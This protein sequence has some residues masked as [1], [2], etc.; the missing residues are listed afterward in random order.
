[1]PNEIITLEGPLVRIR[2]SALHE[3][4]EWMAF[5]EWLEARPALKKGEAYQITLPDG[6]LAKTRLEAPHLAFR[7]AVER[8][9]KTKGEGMTVRVA[10]G[11][12]GRTLLVMGEISHHGRMRPIKKKR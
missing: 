4:P 1:M 9:L 7:K 8:V 2:R 11:S 3:M 6:G 5:V 10:P 12:Q